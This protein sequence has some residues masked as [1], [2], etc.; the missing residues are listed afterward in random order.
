MKNPLTNHPSVPLLFFLSGVSGLIFETVWFRMLIRVF[1]STLEATSTVLAVFMGG[2]AIGAVLAGRR[3]A[4]LDNPLK[5]YA[6][7][8]LLVALAAAGATFLMAGLPGFI[9]PLLP[10]GAAAAALVRLA[11]AAAVLLPPT[12][13]MGT[14]LPILVSHLSAGTSDSG[15]KISR[16]YALNTLGAAL[17]VLASGYLLIGHLGENYS[18]ALAALLN[19]GIALRIFLHNPAPRQAAE[20]DELPEANVPGYRKFLFVMAASGFTALALEVL[21][22]RALVLTIGNSVYAFSAMLGVY[23]LGIALGSL[24]AQERAATEAD[25]LP[26]LA[27]TQAAIAV[28]A[29]A[30]LLVFY[31]IGRTTLDPRYLYSPLTGAADIVALFGWTLLIIFPVTLLMGFFFPLAAQAGVKAAGRV[32]AVGGLYAANTLGTIL[33]SLVTGFVL[34]P[35]LGTKFSFLLIAL[36]A[37]LTGVYLAGLAG[38]EEKRRF[39]PW[40]A[41]A[42]GVALAAFLLPDPLLNI[43]SRRLAAN[44]PGTMVY[45]N[46]ERAGAVAVVFTDGGRRK[47]LYI[48]SVG[49]SG[50][51]AAGKLMSH[52]PLLLQ[53]DPKEMFIVGLGAANTLHSGVLHGVRVTVAELVGSVREAAPLFLRDWKDLSDAGRFTVR[54]NDGRNELLRSRGTYDA[55]IVDVTP[56][57]YSS[58]SVNVYSRDFFKL[59]RRRLTPAG[60][61]SVWIPKPCFESDYFMIL[62]SMREV[63]PRVNVW[64]FPGLPGFLALGSAQDPNLDPKTL[65][66]RIKRGNVAMELPFVTPEFVLKTRFMDDAQ[67]LEGTAAYPPVTDDRPYTEFPLARFLAFSPVWN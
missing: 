11:A 19:A 4:R 58:G 8:E 3:T 35:N 23:L 9:A 10:A 15:G 27:R 66:A 39:T 45:Y 63:F 57:I 37:A 64:H 16:L 60:V 59:A 50:N 22:A 47:S 30:G 24:Y 65:A 21:W 31:L 43:I 33:G 25:Q 12:I 52:F 53:N 46:E 14:T 62:R 55:I 5:L 56:P 7:L 6:I 36:L 61:L 41:V 2:L 29:V 54:L 26:V 18:V 20:Q 67:V 32:G 44:L 42:G 38:E 1:G 17:G 49:V 13:L 48:N 51:G 34:V 40:L 28:L